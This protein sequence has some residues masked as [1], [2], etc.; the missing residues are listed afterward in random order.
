MKETF[1]WEKYDSKL[2]VIA[3][4]DLTLAFYP[5]LARQGQ[6]L[7]EM[8]SLKLFSHE[9][10]KIWKQFLDINVI[11]AINSTSVLIFI[12]FTLVYIYV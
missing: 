11:N 12:M 6:D 4:K 7:N 5:H 10:I 2:K 9:V 8:Q 3:V 1:Y